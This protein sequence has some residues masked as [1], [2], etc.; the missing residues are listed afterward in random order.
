[1]LEFIVQPDTA[2]TLSQ[3]GG[4][5]CRVGVK[6]MLSFSGLPFEDSAEDGGEGRFALAKSLL[7][8]FFRGGETKEVDIEG[9]QWM[10]NFTAVEVEGEGGKREM[11]YMRCWR[12]VTRRSGQKLPRVEVEEMGPRIDFR[13]GRARDADQ[14][15][16]KEAMKKTKGAEVR[17]LDHIQAAH[18]L[19]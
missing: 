2:R 7:L 13:L 10:I 4:S 17:R 19:I 14:T 3:F 16:L 1:M 15:I 5:K 8:D 9:L 11:I 18:M 12:L 6:P